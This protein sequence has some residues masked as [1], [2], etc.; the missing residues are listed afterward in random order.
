MSESKACKKCG[1]IKPLADFYQDRARPDGRR[2][3]CIECDKARKRTDEVREQSHRYYH[4][5]KGKAAE[6]RY[7]H[8]GKGRETRKEYNDRPDVKERRKE[9]QREWSLRFYHSEKGQAKWREQY[10]DPEWQAKR[11]EYRKEWSWRPEV[12]ERVRESARHAV[13]KRTT[14]K[15]GLPATLTRAE[16]EQTVVHFDFRCAYCGE[17]RPLCQDHFIPLSAGGLYSVDNI[18]PSCGHCNSSKRDKM[19]EVWCPPETYER[20]AAYL[21]STR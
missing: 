11:R 12:R 9:P 20:I 15:R 6:R 5:E 21:A 14:R 13:A 19:P 1:I 2:N 16:W 17:D 3:T 8:E 18:V 4:S 10:A 7:Y